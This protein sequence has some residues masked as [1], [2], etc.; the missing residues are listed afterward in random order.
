MN[1]AG[2]ITRFTRA[3]SLTVI[4]CALFFS[5]LSCNKEEQQPDHAPGGKKIGVLLV[6]HGS[7]SEAW[8]QALLDLEAGVREDVLG[9]G[10]AEGIKTAFMEYNEPSIATRLKEYDAE[11]FTDIVVIPIFLTV[12]PHS[13]DDI[14]TIIGQKEDPASMEMLKIEK[15]ERYAP[16]ARIYIAP[17]LDFTGILQKNVLRR[18]E[19]LSTDAGNEG[20]VLIGYGDE[21]YEREWGELFDEV[22][23]YV[24]REKGITE[25]AYG[26]CGHIARYDPGK[27]TDAINRVLKKKRAAIVIPVLVAFDET[28]QV[29][30]IGG[31]VSNVRDPEKRVVYKPDAI[32]PDKNIE[33]WVIDVSREYAGKIRVGAAEDI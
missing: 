30:I 13:F 23:E 9:G 27:T 21:L 2:I 22:A 32:L 17:L 24:K 12:S 16:K 8:R 10:T 5:I 31:G 15:I 7:R 3:L 19:T 11:G 1:D 18:V 33:R 29:K 25:H 14:P 26:W 6:N 28:F 20:L 4:F